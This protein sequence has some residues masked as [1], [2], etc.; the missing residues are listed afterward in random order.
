MSTL[1]ERAL[2]QIAKL[3]EADQDLVWAQVLEDIESELRWD[4]AFAKSE[5]KLSKIAAK[6]KAD[7]KA[8]KRKEMGFDEL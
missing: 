1:K 6:V 4:E 7:I 5:D 8:G 3:P 2:E